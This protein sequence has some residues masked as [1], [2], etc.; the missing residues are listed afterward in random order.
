MHLNRFFP[1]P[2]LQLMALAAYLDGTLSCEERAVMRAFIRQQ[3]EPDER[4]ACLLARV[5]ELPPEL[6]TFD[7]ECLR[8]EL[9][10]CARVLT[11]QEERKRAFLFALR[12]V[13]ATGGVWEREEA[14]SGISSSPLVSKSRMCSSASTAS[15]KKDSTNR[16]GLSFK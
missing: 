14:S 7:A 3:E 2:Y 12:V 4:S 10:A 5:D 1:N 15:T 9:R 13:H 11:K 6:G 8:R 16:S